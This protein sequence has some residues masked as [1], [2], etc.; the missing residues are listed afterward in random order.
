[1][2]RD[3]AK[4]VA[5]MHPM[6]YAESSVYAEIREY[7]RGRPVRYEE[8]SANGAYSRKSTD[9]VGLAMS[10][11]GDGT[12]LACARMFAGSSVPILAVNLGTFGF[13][14]EV[15][16]SEWRS[17]YEKYV[18]GELGISER[19]MLDVTIWRE[20]A[21]VGTMTAL[22]DA[23][24]GTSG[25][26]KLIRLRVNL[27]DTYV[28]RQ[29]ADGVI[30]ATPT[31]STGYS[32]AAGGPILHPEMEAFIL[33]PICPFTLSNRPLV[34][35]KHE[36]LEIEVEEDQRTNIMLTIDGQEAYPLQPKDRVVFRNAKAKSL[37][38]RSDKRNFYEVLR[39][40]L[41]WVSEPNA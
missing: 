3:I 40:K 13:I 31:G 16:A 17:A 32:M 41:N 37:I 29:R 1:M 22:N 11:G 4:V 30:V 25:I 34:V 7:F 21:N 6:K 20:G 8:I 28:C 5:V 15:S 23:V 2:Q 24:I 27:S 9:G 35:H 38:V 36:V 26:S 39:A 14:T 10:L 18:A 33:N 19:I 12:L